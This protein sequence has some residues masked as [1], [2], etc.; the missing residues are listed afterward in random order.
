RSERPSSLTLQA[1]TTLLGGHSGIESQAGSFRHFGRIPDRGGDIAIALGLVVE[2]VDGDDFAVGSL[3]APG[4]AEVAPAR[5]VA[6]D[7]LLVPCV[8]TVAIDAGAN[9][10]RFRTVAV[11][12]TDA[13]VRQPNHARRVA[14]AQVGR[15]C[16]VLLPALA[17]V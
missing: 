10:I 4:I 15:R 14:F 16:L 17:V 13:P 2:V 1:R 7:D 6:Q 11:R 8:A 9:A 3:D 12:Q 5:I